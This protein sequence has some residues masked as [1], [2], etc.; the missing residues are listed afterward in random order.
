MNQRLNAIKPSA[1]VMLMARAKEMQAT[2]PSVISLA[3]GEPDFDTP[4]KITDA[5]IKALQDGDTHYRIGP[6]ILEL[7]E[8]I[9]GKL[10]KENHIICKKDNIIVTPGGKNAIYLAINAII[11]EG[12]EVIILDP[13]WV[14]YEPIVLA[15]GGKTVHIKLDYKDNYRIHLS[16]FEKAVTDRTRLLIINYPNNPTGR[17]LHEDEAEILET[18]M[19]RNPQVYLLADEIYEAIV[20]NDEKSISMGSKA[21]VADRVITVNGFSKSVAMTGWRMGYL[22]SNKTVYET[23]Y[24]LYQHSL[25]CMSGFLQKG[26]VE[27]F[28]CENEIEEMVRIY[29]K[30]RDIFCEILN[31]TPYVKCTIPEGTFYAWV[32]FSIDKMTSADIAEYLLTNAKV[33]GMPGDAYGEDAFACMRFSFANDTDDV[34]EAANRIKTAILEYVK[35]YL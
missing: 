20:F 10:K 16:D 18:F 24:K 26:A 29:K 4:K 15:A 19:L 14:S 34:V 35:H 11:E 25:T 3:G 8:A 23:A 2:D 30:R 21:S 5:A 32:R 6:G 31:S 17:I 1:S 27:A 12:D 22:A 9:E 13:A 33:V 28:N 7:R